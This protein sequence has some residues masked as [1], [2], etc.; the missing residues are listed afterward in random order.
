MLCVLEHLLQQEWLSQAI[1]SL[2][3]VSQP[4]NWKIVIVI[5]VPVVRPPA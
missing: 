4:H 2:S 1:G 5:R 3:V